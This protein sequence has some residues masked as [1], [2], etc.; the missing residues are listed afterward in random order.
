[1]I[2]RRKKTVPVDAPPAQVTRASKEVP[3]YLQP[4]V[5]TVEETWEAP[6]PAQFESSLDGFTEELLRP[7]SEEELRIAEERALF[8]STVERMIEIAPDFFEKALRRSAFETGYFIQGDDDDG[9]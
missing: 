8:R 3:A 7:L 9:K 5:A 4:L 2:F 1:M 6:D